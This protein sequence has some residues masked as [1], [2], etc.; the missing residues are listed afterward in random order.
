MG[1]TDHSKR[2]PTRAQFQVCQTASK[3]QV[4]YRHLVKNTIMKIKTELH[5]KDTPIM[6]IKAIE[7]LT[8]TAEVADQLQEAFIVTTTVYK[9]NNNNNNNNK[10][11]NT[12]KNC[13]KISNGEIKW[14]WNSDAVWQFLHETLKY[15]K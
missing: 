1:T 3:N 13:Y 5:R 2:V 12:M 10:H 15:T 9:H 4:A 6:D 11:S 8:T 14:L 7:K